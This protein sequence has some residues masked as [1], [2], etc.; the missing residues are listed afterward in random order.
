MSK[1]WICVDLEG[2]LAFYDRWRGATH[3]GD[4]IE[5]M[6]DR[7]KEWLAAGKDVRIFT[8]RVSHDGTP[9]RIQ[10]AEDARA[11]IIKWCQAHLGAPLSVTNAK[12]YAMIELWDDRAVQVKQNVGWPIGRS[13]RG[14]S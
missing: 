9:R 3:I 1:G 12:D 5:P 10:E 6:V 7:V 11:A 2:T 4:P 14:L 8:A 13:T